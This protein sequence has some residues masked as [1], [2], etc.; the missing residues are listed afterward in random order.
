ML[1][2][3]LTESSSGGGGLCGG[4]ETAGLEGWCKT[5]VRTG[6]RAALIGRL[7]L[8]VA[9]ANEV[10]SLCHCTPTT[11]GHDDSPVAAE[12]GRRAGIEEIV[13][14]T[15]LRY[16]TEER[17]RLLHLAQAGDQEALGRLFASYMPQLYRV[18]LRMMRSAEDAEDALQDGLLSAV[19]HFREFEGRSQ[20]STWLTRIVFNAALM[21]LRKSRALTFIS[22]D[23]EPVSD[24]DVPLR[25]KI[26]DDRPDPEETYAQREQREILERSLE[27]MP[28]VYVSALWL[29]DVQGMTMEE[30]AQI[31]GLSKGTLKSRLHRARLKVSERVTNAVRRPIQSSERTA[32]ENANMGGKALGALR[33]TRWEERARTCA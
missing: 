2:R 27:T 17:E 25:L 32:D 23:Q 13:N 28:T 1:L 30:T 24:G 12:R 21:R 29:C 31:L 26:A 19:R 22:I 18:A 33:H 20:F 14:S 7:R 15:A 3:Y 9:A 6:T 5:H 16:T 11:L 8:R 10:A 4:E